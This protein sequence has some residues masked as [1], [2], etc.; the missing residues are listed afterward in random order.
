M[1]FNARNFKWLFFSAEGKHICN[2]AQLRRRVSTIPRNL[3]PCLAATERITVDPHMCQSLSHISLL[4]HIIR[5]ACASCP[6][7]S[8]NLY[9]SPTSSKNVQVELPLGEDL[10]NCPCVSPDWPH[11][12]WDSIILCFHLYYLAIQ[13]LGWL[14][15]SFFLL[16]LGHGFLLE[17]ESYCDG[18]WIMYGIYCMIIT[19]PKISGSQSFGYINSAC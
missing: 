16:L 15:C 18:T 6:H 11:M 2:F 1:L 14:V 7:L 17:T 13:F 9:T 10:D 3:T 5:S 8:S 12:L 4:C 19:W